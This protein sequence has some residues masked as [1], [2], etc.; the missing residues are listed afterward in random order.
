MTTAARHLDDHSSWWDEDHVIHSAV[1][2]PAGLT[3]LVS[4]FLMAY[5]LL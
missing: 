1:L 4:L 3:A 2:V 5:A